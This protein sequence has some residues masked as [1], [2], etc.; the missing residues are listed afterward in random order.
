MIESNPHKLTIRN[1]VNSISGSVIYDHRLL[2]NMS[3]DKFRKILDVYFTL[4]SLISARTGA[5][6]PLDARLG[7]IG[8][9]KLRSSKT[10][11]MDFHH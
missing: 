1:D 4:A 7:R 8:I 2:P 10:P 6:I 5:Y 9:H 3:K 11:I